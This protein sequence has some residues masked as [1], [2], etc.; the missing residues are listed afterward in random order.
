MNF[1]M[2]IRLVPFYASNNYSLTENETIT[3]NNSSQT[4]MSD[5]SAFKFLFATLSGVCLVLYLLWMLPYLWFIS[6]APGWYIYSFVFIPLYLLYCILSCTPLLS[7][8]L[9]VMSG[10]VMHL[11]LAIMAMAV[12]INYGNVFF[13]F[14]STVFAV[15]WSTICLARLRKESG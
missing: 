13:A 14:L 11:G 7:G 2:S 6:N 8:R 3:R 5:L 1:K 15:M 4:T 10:V 12:A 9:L